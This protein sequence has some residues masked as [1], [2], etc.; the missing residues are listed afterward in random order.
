MPNITPEIEAFARIKVLGVGGSG[1]NAINHMINSKV[2]GVDFIAINTDAQDLHHSLAK[3]RIHIGKNLT[4]GLGTGMNPEMG[5]RAAEETKEDIQETVKGA[6]MVFVACGLGG[7]TGSGVSPIVARTA[8]E[9]GAL[10]VAVVTRPFFFEGQQRGKIA[11]TALEELRK[12]VDAIIV[13][14]NDRLLSIIDK[15][16]TVKNAFAMCDEILRNSVEGISDLITTPGIINID[17][18]DIRAVM[19]NAG[20]ALM[21]IGHASGENRAIEAAKMAINSPLLDVSIH[22]AK[23][24]LFSIAGGE[25]L[26]MFEIQDAAKVITESIDPQAKVIFGTIRDDKLKKNEVKITV[27][28][29]GFPEG[30][31]VHLAT[32]GAVGSASGIGANSGMSGAKAVP[33]SSGRG[34]A[35]ASNES[36]GKIFNTIAQPEAKEEKAKVE[37]KKEIPPVKTDDDDDWGAVPAF[38]RRS[39]I[40]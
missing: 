5:K 10:T 12:E 28:A 11:E 30:S 21:G 26:T 39:K 17:F 40:K 13:I 36:K 22:G 15:T 4:R 3:K 7:G 25:D 31:P 6:D 16:T 9:L 35:T 14:P 37:E 24:V 34:G 1:G 29:A 27:I 19:E 2:K 20:S 33:F 38:L 18:A 32:M 23:G 8:K